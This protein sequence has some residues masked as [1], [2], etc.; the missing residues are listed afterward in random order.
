[1]NGRL[2][3]KRYATFPSWFHVEASVQAGRYDKWEVRKT[4]EE[5]IKSVALPCCCRGDVGDLVQIRGFL[6]LF[7]A[8]TPKIT[9]ESLLDFGL[10]PSKYWSSLT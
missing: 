9:G 4:L 7:I 8:L 2:A 3:G 1:M 6:P 10:F 5:E